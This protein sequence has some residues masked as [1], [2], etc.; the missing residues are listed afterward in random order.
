MLRMRQSKNKLYIAYDLIRKNSIDA[1][2][3]ARQEKLEEVC[4]SISEVLN[5]NINR[6]IQFGTSSTFLVLWNN[7]FQ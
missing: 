7:F 5:T 6:H 4:G 1:A 2:C 3:S